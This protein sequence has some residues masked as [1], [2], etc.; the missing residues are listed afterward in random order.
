MQSTEVAVI[1][2]QKGTSQHVPHRPFSYRVQA[3]TV[4]CVTGHELGDELLRQGM[5]TLFSE[6]RQ[7]RR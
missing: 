6:A 2:E 7:E 3:R 1:E 5:V 4:L